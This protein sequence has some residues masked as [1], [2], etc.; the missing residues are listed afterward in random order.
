MVQS[1]YDTPEA[2]NTLQEF[3]N[4]LVA[5]ALAQVTNNQARINALSFLNDRYESWRS[6]LK[7]TFLYLAVA[8]SIFLFFFELRKRDV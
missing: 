7:E 8:L 3:E 5:E 6:F 1:G 2:V 4:G